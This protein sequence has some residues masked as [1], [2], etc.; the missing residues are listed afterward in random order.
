L[1]V[2]R[3][4]LFFDGGPAWVNRNNLAAA[5]PANGGPI[6]APPC[7]ACQGLFLEMFFTIELVFTILMRAAEK[8]KATFVA[9]VGIE[10][11]LFVAEIMGVYWT[12]GAVNLANPPKQPHI[13]QSLVS[14]IHPSIDSQTSMKL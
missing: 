5:L 7:R 10:L 9:P 8:T 6:E 11:A 12:G 4:G 1:T 13:A 14:H 3:P 2:Q